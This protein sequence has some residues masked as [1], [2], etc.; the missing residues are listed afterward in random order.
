MD[1]LP[2]A[3][4]LA[5]AVDSESFE[6]SAPETGPILS[7]QWRSLLVAGGGYLV[8]SL[9][10]WSNVWVSHPTSTTVCGCGDSA[11]AIWVMEWPA[12]AIAHGLNPFYTAAMGY[13]GGFNLLSNAA[14]PAIGIFL[15]PVTWLFGPVAS[16]NV[17]L[18]LSPVLSALAMFVLLRRWVQWTPAAFIGGLFYGFCPFIVT[19]LTNAAFNLGMAVVPPL[20][21]ACLDE[22]LIRQRRRPM[23]T[24]ILLGL[25][26]TLQ[27]FISTEVLAM[28][29]MVIVA[30][31]VFLATYA[32]FKHPENLRSHARFAIIGLLVGV[33]IS[34][35]L[36]AYPVWFAI[37]G[38]AHLSEPVWGVPTYLFAGG[39]DGGTTLERF[40]T[41]AWSPA[42]LA[43]GAHNFGG[44]QGP[45]LSWQY[46]GVGIFPVLIGGCIVWRRD[47]RL[48]IFGAVAVISALLSLGSRLPLGPSMSLRLPWGAVE[49]LPLFENIFPSRFVLFTYMA[50]AVMLGLIV[51]YTYR[52]V[53][54]RL[55]EAKD[56]ACRHSNEGTGPRLPHWTGAAVAVVLAAIAIAP[57][58][59]YLAQTI[60][61]TA[62]Q[63]VLPTWF[64]TVAPQLT[65]HQVLLIFPANF[66]GVYSPVAWQAVDRMSFSKVGA[67]GP[68]ASIQQAGKESAAE[69]LLAAATGPAVHLDSADRG[70]S[71]SALLVL[72]RALTA[73]GVT[74]VVIPDQPSLP[75]YD[76]T[77]SVTLG[78][79]LITA[80][81]GERPIHQADAWVWTRL[82]HFHPSAALSGARFRECISGLPARGA[83]AVDSATSCVLGSAGQP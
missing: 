21:V 48:W 78:A 14:A 45:S 68:G 43:A 12:Y 1:E 28:T 46:F 32:A 79:A 83:D 55:K 39:V 22:L 71:I 74:M 58:A 7:P 59:A 49:S 42:V 57:P 47:R 4:S 44:Y 26:V 18:T 80:V 50:V 63:V 67:V 25:L 41:P 81:T 20:V 69:S 23:M 10:I 82:S 5:V 6:V 34:V 13:P 65:R 38:P 31:L 17:A 27:F 35:T 72:R 77:A 36:L 24:G 54:R 16:L 52:A 11:G 60:P 3:R 73:W 51:D 8:L 70:W 9:F 66:G 29:V 62:E 33:M 56:A 75:A 76:Q 64:K 15:A 40:V 19:Y 2:V 30:A 37:A 61:V 53:N